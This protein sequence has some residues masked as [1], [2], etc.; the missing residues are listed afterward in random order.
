MDEREQY[1]ELIRD[2][3]EIDILSKDRRMTLTG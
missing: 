2:N 3:L 1:R